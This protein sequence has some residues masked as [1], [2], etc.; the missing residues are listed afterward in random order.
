MPESDGGP[1]PKTRL[2]LAA[3][4]A[5]AGLGLLADLLLRP[6]P[7]GVNVLLCTGALLAV[8]A[9]L[10][11][12][13]PVAAAGGGRWLAPVALGCA[14]AL[15]WRDSPVLRALN[16][17][18][19]LAALALLLVRLREGRVR[20]AGVV[21]YGLIGVQAGW[22]ALF[23]PLFL[24]LNDVA[25][26]EL[27]REGRW[28]G[29]AR[30]VGRGLLLAAPLLLVFGGLFVAADAVFAGLIA[31]VFRV[32]V[33][34]LFGHLVL[35]GLFAWLLAGVLRV[36]FFERPWPAPLGAPP[37]S[38]A[39]GP[40]EVGVFLGLLNALFLTFVV[41]QVR[42]LFGGEAL[43]LATTGLTYAEYARRGFFELTGV[44]ALVLPM[45][46]AAHWGL[47]PGDR[48]AGRAFRLLAGA[49][50]AL[51]FVIIV[52]AVQRMR[53]YQETY[54][55][56]ELRVYT[57]AFMGWLAIV[58][59]IFALTVL[60]GR[61]ERF[62]FGASVAAFATLALLNA[63]NPDE[64]IAR[65]NLARAVATPDRAFDARYGTS[66]SGDAVPALIDA[67]PTLPPSEQRTVARTL[68]AEW[69]PP[70]TRDWR[71][72]NWGRWRAWDAVAANEAR[73]REYRR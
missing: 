3:L 62:V 46:L 45:L 41:V 32:D 21:E 15:A 26:R 48:A 72:W 38:L 6:S 52:S 55:L 27:P 31:R 59:A 60:R 10:L 35:I 64:V 69:T 18:A 51:L 58:L 33:E 5:A 56:T 66:L 8:V 4:G 16:G 30:A 17:L 14:A 50:I 25:W 47:R 40:I 36:A 70:P 11:R 29:P 71:V 20:R 63:L 9:A 1:G 73:L 67:L 34:A 22:G 49:L 12:L 19:L 44:A 43:V 24:A 61:R 37:A 28:Y 23:G 65:T 68:L 7:T 42:Y 39:L 13:G 54:G 2:G 57:T 53:L